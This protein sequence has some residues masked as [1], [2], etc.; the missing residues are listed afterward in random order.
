M[1]DEHQQLHQPFSNAPR[2]DMLLSN[3]NITNGLA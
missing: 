2:W 3:L 1:F